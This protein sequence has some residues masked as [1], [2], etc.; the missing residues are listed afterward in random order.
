M[1]AK[2]DNFLVRWS[3]RKHAVGAA[4]PAPAETEIEATQPDAMRET[5][6]E[7]IQLAPEQD[8]ETHPPEP[9]P[10]IEDLTPESDISVFLRKGV[11]QAL[12]AAALRR[13][14]SLDPAI[15]DFVGPADYAY[16]FNDPS[17]I[18]GFGPACGPIGKVVSASTGAAPSPSPHPQPSAAARPAPAPAVAD[19]APPRES[20]LPSGVSMAQPEE[21]DAGA[22][23][24]EDQ[25][26]AGRNP[27]A[28]DAPFSPR[29]GKATPR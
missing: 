7:Q 9:L 22:D 13:A 17:S 10:R 29:H 26:A 24:G 4:A 3:R 19:P 2:G 15:R 14:W 8:A 18:P 27:D 23:A 16:D 12:K 28:P 21:P 6:S 11:P 25:N 1:S 5:E 20:V